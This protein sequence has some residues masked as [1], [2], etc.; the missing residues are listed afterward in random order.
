MLANKID[1]PME[2]QSGAHS[3]TYDVDPSFT[4]IGELINHSSLNS[5]FKESLS[6]GAY[7]DILSSDHFNHEY[8]DGLVSKYCAGKEILGAEQ[9]DLL[10]IAMQSTLGPHA[11]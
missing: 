11:D 5:V 8:I 10:N 1:Y 4:H 6:N 3:Y 7:S 2:M 9:A